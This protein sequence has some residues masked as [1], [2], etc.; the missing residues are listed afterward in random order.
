MF[1]LTNNCDDSGFDKVQ[2][3]QTPNHH[4]IQYQK[5][6]VNEYEKGLW[7]P[8]KS[9]ITTGAILDQLINAE[10]E[11]RQKHYQERLQKGRQ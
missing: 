5:I 11:K 10:L 6:S 4:N 3:Y 9:E 7:I 2:L 1:I 8:R